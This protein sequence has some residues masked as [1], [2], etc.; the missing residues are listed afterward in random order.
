MTNQLQVIPS[1]C[2]G[3]VNSKAWFFSIP[4]LDCLESN[5]KEV[6]YQVSLVS[7][8]LK[9]KVSALFLM[10]TELPSATVPILKTS[11]LCFANS[12]STEASAWKRTAIFSLNKAFTVSLSFKEDKS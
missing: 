8:T 7:E 3:K 6:L 5:K 10:V 1:N 11:T 12:A 4:F 9:V 2:L